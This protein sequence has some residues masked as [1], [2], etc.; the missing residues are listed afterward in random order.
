M[1][2][3]QPENPDKTV[4]INTLGCPKNEVDSEI[5]SAHLIGAGWTVVNLPEEACC[6]VVNTCGFISQAKSE[7]IDAIFESVFRRK[8]M[9]GRIVIIGCLA[10]R[11]GEELHEQIPQADAIV[12][13]HRP[14]LVVRALNGE[15][16]PVNG[17]ICLVGPDSG[18]ECPEHCERTVPES[19]YG[20]IKI[21]DGCNNRCAYCIIPTIRGNLRSRS[22]DDVEKEAKLFVEG[23]I[24]ELILVGQDTAAYGTDQGSHQLHN[25]LA[26]LN[27]IP[28]NF[29][30][31][32]L[33]M[34][35]ANL[36]PDIIDSIGSC[37][38]VVPYLDVPLQ[39][40][41]DK[42]LNL[43]LRRLTRKDIEDR[44]RLIR[45]RIQDVVIRSTFLIGH[46]GET[47]AEFD[48][49][50]SFVEDFEF[51]RLGLFAYSPE[52]GTPAFTLPNV[53]ST[54]ETDSRVEHL[55][56][57]Q[58]SIT[59]RRAQRHVGRRLRCLLESP[60]EIYP[61]MWEGRTVADAPG[62]DGAIFATTNGEQNP[63]FADVLV[64]Q[65]DGY[66][67]FGQVS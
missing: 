45:D 53:P 65:A 47:K 62:I 66:D 33:Y 59:G 11:Y 31:R 42:M 64:E 19:L 27:A 38:K 8:Q 3:P 18:Q 37:D 26:R 1:N 16:K 39:H 48:E 49:L 54:S 57:I 41:S 25:L 30:I 56:G 50:V 52:E 4:Y 13:V 55:A 35:P 34:H 10:Q 44:L 23:G 17:R 51:D 32:V 61:G 12:G 60:S 43:M 28:G 22:I 36:T 46:P 29:W 6:E 67:L 9:G 58:E 7:S 24:Q 5:L 14:D 20:Y 63:G 2:T 15:E 40:I 21:S